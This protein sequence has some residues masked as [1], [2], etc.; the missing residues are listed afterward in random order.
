MLIILNGMKI[1]NPWP[2]YAATRTNFKNCILQHFAFYNFSKY[3]GSQPLQEVW[4][5]LELLEIIH[6]TAKTTKVLLENAVIVIFKKN[7]FWEMSHFM[8][9]AGNFFKS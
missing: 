6:E 1:A 9:F 2:M 3:L 7:V 5:A 4:R 8:T